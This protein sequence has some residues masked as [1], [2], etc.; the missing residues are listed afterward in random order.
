MPRW[1]VVGGQGGSGA[2][3][4][5]SI[6]FSVSPITTTSS[7]ESS[8][9]LVESAQLVEISDAEAPKSVQEVLVEHKLWEGW[10][11]YYRTIPLGPG[12]KLQ[13]PR[14]EEPDPDVVGFAYPLAPVPFALRNERRFPPPTDE[15]MYREMFKL[16][17]WA[18]KRKQCSRSSVLS[19]IYGHIN[20]NRRDSLGWQRGFIRAGG[21]AFLFESWREP[22]DV[23]VAPAGVLNRHLGIRYW[24]MAVLGRMLGTS[25]ESRARLIEG[26]AIGL[27]I[28][29]TRAEDEMVV[30]CALYALKGLVQHAEGRQLI[31]HNTLLECLGQHKMTTR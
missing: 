3:T 21:I 16:V 14:E 2:H 1:S 28:E 7:Q 5:I 24:V 18:M 11:K 20:R 8:G 9:E 4:P 22:E 15:R 27:I 12:Q 6:S 13:L 17:H 30:D 26:G 10:S 29:G 23:L 19:A 31:S 25:R